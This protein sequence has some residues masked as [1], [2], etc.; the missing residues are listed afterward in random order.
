MIFAIKTAVDYAKRYDNNISAL[1]NDLDI[2]VHKIDLE[3]LYGFT[4]NIN[5]INSIYMLIII[6]MNIA[7]NI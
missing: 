7:K 2:K 5:G 4:A 1:I 6:L 3:S